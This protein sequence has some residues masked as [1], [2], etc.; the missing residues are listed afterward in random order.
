MGKLIVILRRNIMEAFKR[1][2][3]SE[4]DDSIEKATTT[5]KSSKK[6]NDIHKD[7]LTGTKSVSDISVATAKEESSKIGND[8]HTG[9]LTG[10]KSDNKSV[11]VKDQII[12]PFKKVEKSESS[13]TKK[14]KCEVKPTCNSSSDQVCYDQVTKPS[15]KGRQR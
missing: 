5:I 10:T 12:K 3:P 15:D 1:K 9:D 4:E 11:S 14:E 2:S 6:E 8:I 13:D 7:N